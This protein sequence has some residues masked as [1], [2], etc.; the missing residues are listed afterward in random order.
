VDVD[1]DWARDV[2]KKRQKEERNKKCITSLVPT[3]MLGRQ[4][5]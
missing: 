2:E 5:S 3:P 1:I 4:L